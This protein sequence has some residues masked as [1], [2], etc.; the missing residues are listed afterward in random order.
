MEENKIYEEDCLI[1]MGRMSD[2]YIDLT[3]TSPPYDNIR[4]YDGYV[5]DFEKTATEL[6]RVTKKGG[7]VVWVVGDE[8]VKGSETGT[9]FRQALFFISLGFR[10]HDTM[11][12]QKHNFSNPSINRYHQ[13]FEYMFVFSKGAPKT[14]NPIIDR[15]N[16]EAG[17][18]GSWGKNTV[19]QKDGSFKERDK[20]VNKEFG[21]RYN[22]WKFITESNPLQP[23]QFPE[24]L[25]HDHIISWSNEGDIVYDPM[26]GA[27]TTAKMAI[28]LNRRWIMS[29]MS[30]RSCNKAND[31]IMK[32]M[33][34]QQLSSN[35]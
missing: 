28:K 33:A 17:K 6:F 13:I 22:I 29:E 34:S 35:I 16:K 20:K 1:T 3:V 31:R 21:M 12:Y 14:F 15:Q 5:F 18:I 25:A 11:I 9:S 4:D 30:H 23:S 32:Y 19:R 10:L 27:G 24:L 7:I 26:G 8:T 2:N